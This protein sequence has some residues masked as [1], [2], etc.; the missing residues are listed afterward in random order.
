[1][2]LLGLCYSSGIGC[3]ED[4]ARAV[5]WFLKAARGGHP[6]AQMTV[7][8]RYRWGEG[9]PKDEAEYRYWRDSA[10]SLGVSEAEYLSDV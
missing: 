10:E 8:L 2:F 3:G 1:M 9:L 6:L 5:R 4:P 7:A